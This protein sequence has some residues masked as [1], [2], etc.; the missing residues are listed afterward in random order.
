MEHGINLLI[1]LSCILI[2]QAASGKHTASRHRLFIVLIS[3]I[4]ITRPEGLL[5]GPVFIALNG[6]ISFHQGIRGRRLIEQLLFPVIAFVLVTVAITMFRLQYFGYPFPNTY[7]AKVSADRIYNLKEGVVYLAKY[8]FVY[9]LYLL[10]LLMAGFSV[11][12]ILFRLRQRPFKDPVLLMQFVLSAIIL[13]CLFI[14]C[15]VGGDHFPLFRQYQ[16]LMPLFFL[17]FFNLR[18]FE[19][20][21]GTVQFLPVLRKPPYSLLLMLIPFI[22]LI[23][24]PKYLIDMKKMP[25]KVS[26]L[27]DFEIAEVDKKEGLFLNRF[28]D[29]EPKPSIGRHEAGGHAYGYEGPVVDLLGLNNTQMAHASK[30]K[31]GLKNH[32]SFN[33]EVFYKLRPDFVLGKAIADTTNFVLPD[34]QPG[35][36]QYFD[37]VALKKLFID[38]RFVKEYQP[39]LIN[40]TGEDTCV[41]TYVRNDYIRNLEQEGYHITVLKRHPYH[42]DKSE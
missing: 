16:P 13:T 38:D 31:I 25:D 42:H 36:D 11:G 14:P 30:L 6:F 20:I 19:R 24:L 15:L 26:L 2:E 17:C 7:Y 23:C 4:P 9:P 29:K 18:F 32:A 27:S 40:K 41:F 3:I 1:V 8:I 28:F 39:V 12:Y 35:F 34:N 10:P 5:W 33:K 37:N 21:F 22:Y